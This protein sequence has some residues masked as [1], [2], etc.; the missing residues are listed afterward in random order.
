M[1]AAG[2]VN[3]M[4]VAGGIQ[5]VCKGM[6]AGG[7]KSQV[8]KAGKVSQCVCVVQVLWEGVCNVLCV[9]AVCPTKPLQGGGRQTGRTLWWG[10]AGKNGKG[11]RHGRPGRLAVV[12]GTV[13]VRGGG[14][15]AGRRC[16]CTG[17]GA[18]VCVQPTR[19][20]QAG[21]YGGRQGRTCR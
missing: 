10:K 9:V 14:G 20:A 6:R 7:S 12:Q 2:S 16:V 1:V 21:R 13:C 11:G 15:V 8:E 4:Y 17:K 5:V 19:Q 18:G 3:R